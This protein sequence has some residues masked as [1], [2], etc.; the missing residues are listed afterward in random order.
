MWGPGSPQPD[1]SLPSWAWLGPWTSTPVPPRPACS[2]LPRVL[3]PENLGQE[4]RVPQGRGGGWVR[5]RQPL[6]TPCPPEAGWGLGSCSRHWAVAPKAF[7]W[8]PLPG[9][10]GQDCYSFCLPDGETEVQSYSSKGLGDT[11]VWPWSGL[12]SWADVESNALCGGAPLSPQGPPPTVSHRPEV[13]SGPPGECSLAW[14]KLH[15]APGRPAE[16][17]RRS[18]SRTVSGSTTHTH[19]AGAAPRAGGG[20]GGAQGALQ[21]GPWA[22]AGVALVDSSL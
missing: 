17:V 18:C 9:P 15:P 1:V 21:P 19:R 6:S 20:G 10:K 7:P 8:S 4:K 22:S 13:A 3:V 11:T 16:P 14:E 5:L 12:P 2:P